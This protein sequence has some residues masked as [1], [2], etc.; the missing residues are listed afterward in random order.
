MLYPSA[1][2][3][4]QLVSHVDMLPTLAS[5][6]NAPRSARNP[7]WAGIDYSENVLGRT[8]APT[9][10]RVVFT[11]D[12]WQS[13]QAQGPYVPPPNH[14]VMLRERRWKLA[15]Y[16]GAVGSEPAVWEM[17]DLRKDPLERQNITHQPRRMTPFQRGHFKRLR[18]RIYQAQHDLLQPLP[19]EAFSVR[20]IE[21]QG[22]LLKSSLRLP[23]RGTVKQ[24]AFARVDGKR[25][26]V[27]RSGQLFPAAGMVTLQLELSDRLP[28]RWTEVSVVTHWRPD[29]GA[30]KR[31]VR[32]V[33][34]RRP[35]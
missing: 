3:S 5:L 9:Q 33:R 35:D 34:V 10:E 8:A 16:Y 2:T 30:R 15:K 4:N 24:A 32:T 31:V 1:R 25:R 22:A 29:G 12:D 13:G 23:G 18:S 27:G 26:R 21:P 19:G 11:F 14:I 17:Y 6:V 7:E 20:G 28:T